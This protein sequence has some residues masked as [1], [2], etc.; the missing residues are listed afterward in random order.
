MTPSA[1]LDQVLI[2]EQLQR[3]PAREVD[4]QA[5]ER[6]VLKLAWTLGKRP[7]QVLQMAAQSA[8]DLCQV[9]TVSISILENEGGKD[10]FRWRAMAGVYANAIGSTMPREQSPCGMVL[11]QD[12][13]LL[14]AYPELHFPFP[15][16]MD[17]P[18]R[19]VLLTPFHN[20]HG[21][22]VGTIW[23]VAH[24]EDRKFTF[25]DVRVGKEL[26]DFISSA[27]ST[28]LGLGYVQNPSWT[29]QPAWD[30]SATAKG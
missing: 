28:L 26:A 22:P 23:M 16:P 2:T 11:D 14:F 7:H 19:E 13:S 27:L 30:G 4:F 1:T 15:G 25:E 10:V 3:R 20:R 18:I 12:T 5:M 6:A 21:V 24:E 17:P 8:L 9:Q 29:H